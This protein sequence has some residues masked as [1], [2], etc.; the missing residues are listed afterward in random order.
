MYSMHITLVCILYES[1]MDTAVCNMHNMHSKSTSTFT[2]KVYY[3]SYVHTR[4]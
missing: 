4:S 1:S 2:G 3:Q